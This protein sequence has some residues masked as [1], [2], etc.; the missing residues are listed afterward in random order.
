M[1]LSKKLITNFFPEFGL[2]ND[3]KLLEI[4]NSLGIELETIFN[5]ENTN[6]LVVGEILETKKHPSADNLNLCKVKISSSKIN[7]IV[8]GA[9]NVHQGQKVIV[10]L[11]GAKF[12]DG[13]VIEYKELRG[14]LSEGMICAYNELT[15]R[16]DWCN[17]NELDDIITL[18]SV[19]KVGD[20]APLNFISMND[21]IYEL[22]I[23]S[24]R[25]DLNSVFGIILEIQSFLNLKKELTFENLNKNL[26]SKIKLKNKVSENHYLIS[27][28]NDK[29]ST[30]NWIVKTLLMNSGFVPSDSIDDLAKLNQ[31]LSGIPTISF[32][33][34][35]GNN[36]EISKLEK[37]AKVELNT[38]GIVNLKKGDIVLK[39]NNDIVALM[40]I[41]VCKKYAVNQQ[42]KKVYFLSSAT[43]SMDVRKTS[44]RLKI[45]NDKVK[46]SL[47]KISS[48]WYKK[49]LDILIENLK[50]NFKNIEVDFKYK[51]NNQ[52]R[53]KLSLNKV[54]KLLGIN[55]TD[56]NI[57]KII[58][59]F[60]Y[61]LTKDYIATPEYRID[62][63]NDHD[64]IEDILKV[65][66]IQN[67]PEISIKNSNV[68]NIK[69][70]DSD[71]IAK[72]NNLL[73]N[74]GF[75][76]LKT[77]NLTSKQNNDNYNY[78]KY[79]KPIQI[80][81]P[82][83]SDREFMRLSLLDGILS[84][85]SYNIS[86]K[87]ELVP[88]FEIQEVYYGNSKRKHLIAAISEDLVINVFNN[89]VI[90]S[91]IFSLKSIAQSIAFIANQELNF[92]KEICDSWGCKKDS[93]KV[94][95]D[96]NNIGYITRMNPEVLKSY[97]IKSEKVYVMELD[98]TDL[99]NFQKPLDFVFED[100]KKHK[101]VR[102][103]SII[104]DKDYDLNNI[105]KLAKS[106][107]LLEDLNFI[108]AF[109]KE[110]EVS[111][112]FRFNLI[113]ND[114]DVK[115]NFQKVIEFFSKNKIKIITG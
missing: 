115:T 90:K 95:I 79:T 12:I 70:K 49:S 94:N 71:N 30:S 48:W 83:S 43:N 34:I 45:M 87:N 77:Y 24:N 108:G 91:D 66:G 27:L 42:S 47:K 60:G 59:S 19:A 6:N 41:D 39:N 98:I 64:I 21:T 20:K 96:K 113:S 72:V 106:C 105:Y 8:C 25:N 38:Y 62:I 56:A 50:P 51:E 55:I 7:T 57:K 2:F 101:I 35:K 28:N 104:V 76:L 100:D 111:Y 33:N 75:Y 63:E 31:I 61:K 44:S 81:N 36:L 37:P 114:S 14:I 97:K 82:I 9:K 26:N 15:N 102:D 112:T 99:I 1:Y 78:F 46:F 18:P 53:I 67:I 17:K 89:S 58:S 103:I 22:S 84:C 80:K 110:N 54:N 107:N 13:R 29:Y 73:L 4:F 40:N 3:K 16:T 86:L 85:Y 74:R 88:I 65:I 69:I 109:E 23:P 52:N 10:A 68:Y 92:Q 5:F 32:T 11:K 93:I